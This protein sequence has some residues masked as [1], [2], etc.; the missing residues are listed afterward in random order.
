M[1][2]LQLGQSSLSTHLLHHAPCPTLV[3]PYKAVFA[4]DSAYSADAAASPDL[5][6]GI[7]AAAEDTPEPSP[8]RP[9]SAGI[10]ATRRASLGAHE[11][12]LFVWCIEE[13]LVVK[14]CAKLSWACPPIP[15]C[16]KLGSHSFI[17]LAILQY[18][19]SHGLVGI[20]DYQ[21]PLP[22]A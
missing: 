14:V 18:V 1:P 2:Q 13:L 19:C 16:T 5:A 11:G 8:A 21:V 22:L 4:M 7:A 3:I 12:A 10:A 9:G 6:A 20:P 15:L 17:H